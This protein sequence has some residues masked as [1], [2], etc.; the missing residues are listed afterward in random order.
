MNPTRSATPGLQRRTWVVVITALV[1]LALGFSSTPATPAHAA[2]VGTFYNTISTTDYT[3]GG[4]PFMTKNGSEYIYTQSQ[5]AQ[6]TIWRSPTITGL[7]AAPSKVI[8][9]QQDAGLTELWAP[10]ANLI[11]GQSAVGTER[12]PDGRRPPWPLL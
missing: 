1:V 2:G 12:S 4:D 7:G 6:I 8:F 10:E 9:R 3:G 5:G 11:N